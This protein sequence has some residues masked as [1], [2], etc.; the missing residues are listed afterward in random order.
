MIAVRAVSHRLTGPEGH[1]RA[2]P[3]IVWKAPPWVDLDHCSATQRRS[4]LTHPSARLPRPS[5]L[6]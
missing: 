2:W 4:R 5:R 6:R 3:N 1:L